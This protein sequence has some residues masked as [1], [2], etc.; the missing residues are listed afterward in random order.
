M[1]E[2]ERWVQT[3]EAED[4]ASSLR[5]VLRCRQYVSEDIH[6]CKWIALALHSALQGACVCHL[7]TTASP[8]GAITKRNAGEWLAYFEESRDNPDARAPDAHLLTLPDLLKAVRKPLSAG[9]RSNSAGVHLTD[10]ELEWLRRVH[11]DVRN[12]FVH[13]EPMG[14]SLEISGLPEL[15]KLIARLIEEM[16]DI[17]WA[18]RHKD[19]DWKQTLRTNLACLGSSDW[20]INSGA[21]H[22]IDS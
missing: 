5:H 9:D 2:E 3:D 22:G 11:Q 7:V 12:Q 10:G 1:A 14:W 21:P 15:G 16:L 13:F 18:F 4:V 8:V 17:G 19:D 20:T 6:I